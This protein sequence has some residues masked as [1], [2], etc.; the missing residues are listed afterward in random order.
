MGKSAHL[1]QLSVSFRPDWYTKV[2]RVLVSRK[3]LLPLLKAPTSLF[4][5]VDAFAESLLHERPDP[6][7]LQELHGCSVNVIQRSAEDPWSEHVSPAVV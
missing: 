6:A 1:N 4:G 2:A 5:I 7:L 3:D